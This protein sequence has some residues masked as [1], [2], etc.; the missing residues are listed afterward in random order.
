MIAP[1]TFAVIKVVPSGVKARSKTWIGCSG[2]LM[3]GLPWAK[4]QSRTCA[5]ATL[6]ADFRGP[7][8]N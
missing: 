6:N 1:A 4:S 3:R 7:K 8:N 5:G 2:N